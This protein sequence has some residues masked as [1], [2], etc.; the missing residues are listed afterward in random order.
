MHPTYSLGAVSHLALREKL[1]KYILKKRVL[2]YKA[3]SDPPWG[4]IKP[5]RDAPTHQCPDCGELLHTALG[6]HLHRVR[7]HP[8]S[9]KEGIGI[10]QP[11]GI[12]IRYKLSGNAPVPQKNQAKSWKMC[13]SVYCPSCCR[14]FPSIALC[15]K[16]W[17]G[18]CSNPLAK[19]CPGCQ[20]MIKTAAKASW[21]LEF[22]KKAQPM[23]YTVACTC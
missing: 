20:L 7:K 15:R 23:V 5:V 16:H 9:Y 1:F 18:T 3:S 4:Q 10:R 13:N 22:T 2:S 21:K 12:P 19:K 17:S 8:D 6:L 11:A 14:K